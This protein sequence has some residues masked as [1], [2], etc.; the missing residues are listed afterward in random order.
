MKS[1]TKSI[2]KQHYRKVVQNNYLQQT[3]MVEWKQQKAAG[4]YAGDATQISQPHVQN[5][6]KWQNMKR[7]RE[8]GKVTMSP[9]P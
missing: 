3:Q 9:G 7:G 1:W 6:E 4:A 2:C 5:A 8:G